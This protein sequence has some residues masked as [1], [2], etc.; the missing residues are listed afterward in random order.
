MNRFRAYQRILLKLMMK[1]Y[2]QKDNEDVKGATFSF[3]L[4]LADDHYNLN[5]ESLSFRLC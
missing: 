1:R 4:T 3:S 2:G 5:I